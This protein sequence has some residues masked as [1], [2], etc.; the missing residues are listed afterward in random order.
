MRPAGI[1]ELAAVCYFP[2]AITLFIAVDIAADDHEIHF[3]T[4]FYSP[5]I[6]LKIYLPESDVAFDIDTGLPQHVVIRLMTGERLHR[7]V[8]KRIRPALK[9][10]AIIGGIIM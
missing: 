5:V 2:A 10:A 8:H 3:R 6:G 7:K 9:K 1:V 4:I